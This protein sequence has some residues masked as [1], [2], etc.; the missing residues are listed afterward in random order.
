MTMCFAWCIVGIL[1]KGNSWGRASRMDRFLLDTHVSR[2]R[3]GSMDETTMVWRWEFLG[4][5]VRFFKVFMPSDLIRGG[6]GSSDNGH[7]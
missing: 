6:G 2:R 1:W 5:S 7:P 4:H 3:P